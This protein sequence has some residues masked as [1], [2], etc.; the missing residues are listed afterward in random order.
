MG[1]HL[2]FTAAAAAAAAD[3]G[4]GSGSGSQMLT[5]CAIFVTEASPHLLFAAFCP[6]NGRTDA[7]KM[8]GRRWRCG[9]AAVWRTKAERPLIR[10][11]AI[12][13]RRPQQFYRRT[14]SF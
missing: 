1:S 2:L 5:K 6:V 10:T 13:S 8:C 3:G 7:A 9:W 11:T 4:G 14:E 12:I